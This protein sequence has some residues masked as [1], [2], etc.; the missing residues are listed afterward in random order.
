MLEIRSGFNSGPIQ[1]PDPAFN[2]NAYPR[3]R[4][5]R[6]KPM[7]IHADLDTGQTFTSQ[8]IELMY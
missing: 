6:A 5:Q 8:K 2:F 3:I 4:I 1:D 7:R